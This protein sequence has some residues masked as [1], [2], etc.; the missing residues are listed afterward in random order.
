MYI[1]QTG[2]VRVFAG[3]NGTM[4][5]LAYYRGGDFFGELSILN[6]SP[7]AA[8]VE[9]MTRCHLLALEPT[10][11]V[12]LKDAYPEFR[13][14][15]DERLARY[16]ANEEARIPLDFNEESLPPR[17]IY[18]LFP[19]SGFRGPFSASRSQCASRRRRRMSIR[20]T[21]SNLLR[22]CGGSDVVVLQNEFLQ[23]LVVIGGRRADRCVSKAGRLR[24][25]VAVECSRTKSAVYPARS[26]R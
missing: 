7:R 21:P 15:L 8:T 6:G 24:C 12:K 10:R 19:S 26:R 25:G 13:K 4:R 17:I 22:L 2:R 16:Q 18:R 5:N 9:A 14:L 20:G 11:C 23:V 1:L 3:K